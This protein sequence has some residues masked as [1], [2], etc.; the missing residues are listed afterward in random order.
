MTYVVF[1]W[2]FHESTFGCITSGLKRYSSTE[3]YEQ[4][5]VN[6]R[7][8]CLEEIVDKPHRFVDSGRRT[9]KVVNIA[10]CEVISMVPP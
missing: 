3:P 7:R 10:G 6:S 2:R 1:S 9:V 8:K 5:W 4:I